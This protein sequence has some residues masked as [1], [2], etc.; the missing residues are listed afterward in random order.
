VNGTD[1]PSAPA[2]VSVWVG[3]SSATFTDCTPDTDG[4]E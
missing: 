1:T 3:T 4:L 2:T